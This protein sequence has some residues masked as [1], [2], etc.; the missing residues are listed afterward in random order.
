[1][2]ATQD[3]A[4]AAMTDRCRFA[5]GAGSSTCASTSGGPVAVRRTIAT[6]RDP[7]SSACTTVPVTTETATGFSPN[8]VSSL[9]IW[10][11]FVETGIRTGAAVAGAASTSVRAAARRSFISRASRERRLATIG[12]MP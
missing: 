12:E 2:A 4:E 9:P 6:P 10:S 1:M 11:W 5:F 8:G 3:V 7:R